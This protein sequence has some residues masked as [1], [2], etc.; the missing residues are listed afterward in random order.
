MLRRV[1]HCDNIVSSKYATPL[2]SMEIRSAKYI[3]RPATQP[4]KPFLE[5]GKNR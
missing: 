2:S 5:M 3:C 1:F 4:L